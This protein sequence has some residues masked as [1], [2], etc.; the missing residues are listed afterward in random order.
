V[1][2]SESEVSQYAGMGV[3]KAKVRVIYNGIDL[4][5][6]AR[7]PEGAFKESTASGAE[8]GPLP[9]KDNPEE[10]STSW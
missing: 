4:D 7:L 9:R 8:G 6:F 10:G 3:D 1:A 2:V 5:G